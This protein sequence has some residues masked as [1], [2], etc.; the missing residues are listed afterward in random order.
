MA[1]CTGSKRKECDTPE[2]RELVTSDDIEM[3]YGA[4]DRGRGIDIFE[5][6]LSDPA[7][8]KL[9]EILERDTKVRTLDIKY[10][11]FSDTSVAALAKMLK[12][13]STLSELYLLHPIMSPQGIFT[14]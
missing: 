1:S 14:F 5:V 7:S 4:R 10:T 8:C 11:S 2:S 13:N 12:S 3:S 6:G 9:F